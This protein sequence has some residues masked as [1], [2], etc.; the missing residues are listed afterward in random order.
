MLIQLQNNGQEVVVAFGSCSLS[1]A[2]KQY[3]ITR[4]EA[5]AFIWTLGHFHLYLSA[6]P[7]LWRTDHRALKFIFDAS[8]TSIPALQRYKLIA[9][10][11]RFS[12]EW[13]PGTK[14]IADTMSRLCI[15]P[16]ERTSTMTTRE[17]LTVKLPS[18]MKS[19]VD[20]VMIQNER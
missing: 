16:T 5:L 6:K 17:M 12:T 20:K 1:K 7:F 3:H 15:I 4:L 19:P 13:I 9:D 14:M 8:K 11:Y 2:Q 10:D 18:L